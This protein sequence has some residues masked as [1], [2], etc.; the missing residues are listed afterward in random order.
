CRPLEPVGAR[1]RVVRDQETSMPVLGIDVDGQLVEDDP[2]DM[3]IEGRIPAKVQADR[4]QLGLHP[5]AYRREAG[6][7]YLEVV[8]VSASV[9]ARP[10]VGHGSVSKAGHVFEDAFATRGERQAKRRLRAKPYAS[11][12]ASAS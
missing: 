2:Q 1:H 10:I 6:D 11:L 4:L 12:A 3:A 5:C 8:A 7:L 9:F